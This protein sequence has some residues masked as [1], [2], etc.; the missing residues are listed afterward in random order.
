MPEHIRTL[1]V[2]LFL[3]AIVFSFARRP[4]CKLINCG[5]FIRRRNLWLALTLTAF[6]AHNYWLY[7]V[8]AGFL[9]HYSSKREP[10]KVALF[11][12]VL[13]ALPIASANIPGLGIV[14]YIFSFSY[15]RLLAWLYF[16]LH[17]FIC[18]TCVRHYPSVEP[19]QISY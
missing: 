11:F 4:A 5:D 9:L 6:L 14:N 8:I 15:P 2:I 1:F 17:L 7:V 10:N 16:C 13:F 12:F 19:P 18:L 3:S